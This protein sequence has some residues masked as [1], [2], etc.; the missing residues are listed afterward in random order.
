MKNKKLLSKLIIIFFCLSSALC[1]A[2]PEVKKINRQIH[3][4]LISRT[5]KSPLV[6]IIIPAFNHFDYTYNCLKAISAS[7]GSTPYEVIIVDDFSSD[8]TWEKLSTISNIRTFRNIKNLGFIKSCNRGAQEARGNFLIFLNNDT[9]PQKGWVEAMISVFDNYVDTGLV[10]AK[11]LYP[12]GKLQEAGS[13]LYFD[14]SGYRYGWMQNS[15]DPRFNFVREVDYCSGAAIMIKAELFRKL[16]GFDTYFA[17]AYYEDTDLAQKVRQEGLRV[18]YQPKAEV[19]HYES[20]TCSEKK[21]HYM[22]ENHKKFFSRWKSF[23]I[24]NPTHEMPIELSSEHRCFKR[25]LVID[26]ENNHSILASLIKLVNNNNKIYYFPFGHLFDNEYVEQCQRLG[27]EIINNYFDEI[28]LQWLSTYGKF[29][30]FIMVPDKEKNSSIIPMIKYATKNASL[31]YYTI[32]DD[33][34]ELLK[35]K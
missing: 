2:L 22:I 14:G 1:P 35:G 23:L 21:L 28:A 33:L 16:K 11:L 4:S 34:T 29:L 7:S 31:I 20:I 18:I 3:S 9:E 12:D 15:N 26:S 24:N 25:I 8:K 5:E 32:K 30:N 19:I 10:G 27:I 6:S 17:P 13:I